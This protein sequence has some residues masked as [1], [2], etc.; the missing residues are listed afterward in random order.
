MEWTEREEN[1]TIQ[2]HLRT[3][4][5]NKH[6]KIKKEKRTNEDAQVFI[7]SIMKFVS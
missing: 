4:N 3:I 1:C 2:L 7:S 6:E 5:K